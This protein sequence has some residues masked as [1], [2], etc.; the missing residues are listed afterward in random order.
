M[1]RLPLLLALLLPACGGGART[2]AATPTPAPTPGSTLDQ[3]PYTAVVPSSYLPGRPAPLLVAL[4]GYGSNGPQMES[5]FRLSEIAEREGFLSVYPNGTF[6]PNGR[7]FWNAT[8]ACCNFFGSMVDDVAYIAAIIDDMSSKYAVDPS[9]VFVAGHSNGAFM[10]NR[11]GCDLAG[12]VA[13]IVSFAGATWEDPARCATVRPVSV[14]LIHGDADPTIS[15][16][17]GVDAATYPSAHA[18][19]AT[20]AQKNGCTGTLTST[21]RTLDLETNLAGKETRIDSTTGCPDGG[22]VDLWTIHGGGHVPSLSP[23]FNT[24]IWDWLADHP[25]P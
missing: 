19:A 24:T 4:H 17:G 13:A 15:Y 22:A 7:A 11:V 6:D 5:Y 9:R 1:K 10:A 25:R 16:V 21:G 2:P 18:T 23:A 8:N 3:R 12:R 20:W 14:L